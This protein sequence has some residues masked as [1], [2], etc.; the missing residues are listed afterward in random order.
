MFNS[1]GQKEEAYELARLGLK[2]D[3]KSHVCWHVLGLLYR[4]DRNYPE[5]T[6]CYKSALRMDPG[7]A[8]IMRDLS[9][10]QL[11]VRDLAGYTE[12]RRQ[13]LASK[14]GFKQNW[15]S[16]AVAEHMRGAPLAA[17]Q[18]LEKMENSFAGQE[19]PLGR[20]EASEMLLYKAMLCTEAGRKDLA[21]SILSSQGIVDTVARDEMLA[22]LL[23]SQG[24]MEICKKAIIHL[25]RTNSSHEGYLLTALAASGV[26]TPSPSADQV[27]IWLRLEDSGYTI[28]KQWPTDP[29]P[30]FEVKSAL[31]LKELMGALLKFKEEF[32]GVHAKSEHFDE[33][34]LTLMPADSE[35]FKKIM[36]AFI[37]TKLAK[38]V[39][40]T[41]KKLRKFYKDEAKKTFIKNLL[42]ELSDKKSLADESPVIQ[43]F[44][45]MSL[46]AHHDFVGEHDLA[47]AR[48]E[49]ALTLTPTLIDLLVL[50]AKVLKHKGDLKT[51][52]AVWEE[53][54]EMDLADRYLNSKSVKALL[55]IGEI[56]KAKETIALF[57]KDTADSSK[58]N[59]GEMQCMWWEFELGKALLAKGDVEGARTTWKGTLKHYEDMA[60]DEFDFAFY[61]LRKMTLRAYIDFLRLQDKLRTHKFYKRAQEAIA[62]L[63]AEA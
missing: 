56:D 28:S 3:L 49:Q 53:A 50:K 8:Q 27:K 1:L 41:F 36:E 25:L 33:I 19:E 59:L 12:S 31:P 17:L 43:T 18:V 37:V 13:L 26:L 4:S 58:S 22:Y 48:I 63:V 42:V 57:S 54:R 45:L 32:L 6:K 38:G 30:P 61:C 39:P 2:K 40:S 60:E 7:N 21:I 47:L 10:L 51:S 5:A 34:G 23:Y 29:S 9:L 35:E 20:Y 15:L 46:A 14:P 62:S 44:A 52:S 11:H 55:R 16:F 24:N